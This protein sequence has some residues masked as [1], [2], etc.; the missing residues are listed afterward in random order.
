MNRPKPNN[1]HMPS[2]I[3]N[4]PEFAPLLGQPNPHFIQLSEVPEQTAKDNEIGSKAFMPRGPLSDLQMLRALYPFMPILPLPAVTSAIALPVANRAGDLIIPNGMVLCLLRGN[5][6]Y[7]I[8][9]TGSAKV[10]T[11]ANTGMAAG[12]DI[13]NSF[14]APEGT[15]WYVQGI[16]SISVVSPLAD[17]LISALFWPM[18]GANS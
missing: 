2:M 15:Y 5:Q 13:C 7:Y 18:M 14:F 16:P 6:D 4:N 3:G 8:S 10:P 1:D 17:T 11:A 12:S 9:T